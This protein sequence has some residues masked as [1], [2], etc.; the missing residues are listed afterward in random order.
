VQVQLE[1]LL[2]NNMNEIEKDVIIQGFRSCIQSNC[3]GLE[4]TTISDIGMYIVIILIISNILQIFQ[5][6]Q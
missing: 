5:V 4:S 1:T 3:D 2:A 6:I